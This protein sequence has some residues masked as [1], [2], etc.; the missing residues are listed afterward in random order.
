MP[1]ARF[2]QAIEQAAKG[3]RQDLRRLA[4]LGWQVQAPFRD[5]GL[6]YSQ[7]LQELGLGEE[8]KSPPV[9]VTKDEA[10]DRAR[11]ILAKFG[12]GR[13]SE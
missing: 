13:P 7:Y 1:Y 5:R 3:Y 4:F 9:R 8:E 2:L 12:I 10:L 11:E 6:S